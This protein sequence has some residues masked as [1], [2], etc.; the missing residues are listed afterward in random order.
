M[1]EK[2]IKKGFEVPIWHKT[3]LSIEEAAEY[4]GI[5]R[6]KLRAMTSRE[7][8]PYVLWIGNRR[9]IKRRLFDE[10]IEKSYSI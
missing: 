9:L 5:G 3:N 7:D 4:T 2:N 1:S 8:C 10:Y 6:D